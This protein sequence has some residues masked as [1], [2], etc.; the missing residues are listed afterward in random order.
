MNEQIKAQVRAF[1][2]QLKASLPEHL[3]E[4]PVLMMVC[5]GCGANVTN[6]NFFPPTRSIQLSDE[7]KSELGKIARGRPFLPSEDIAFV[8]R[9][10][11]E[12]NEPCGCEGVGTT[13]HRT[14]HRSA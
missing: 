14:L 11:P 6:A 8:E 10:Q 3:R 4:D 1:G 12:R 5:N 2:E 13:L 7:A 9:L